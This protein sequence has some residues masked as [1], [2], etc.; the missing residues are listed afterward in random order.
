MYKLKVVNSSCFTKSTERLVILSIVD[1]AG[2]EQVSKAMKGEKAGGIYFPITAVQVVP[3]QTALSLKF[4]HV[5]ARSD[6]AQCG[7]CCLYGC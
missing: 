3:S 4:E 7:Y 5:S 6:A 2:K 1:L